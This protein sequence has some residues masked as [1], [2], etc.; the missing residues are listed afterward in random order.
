MCHNLILICFIHS[1]IIS[2][3]LLCYLMISCLYSHLIHHVYVHH[4]CLLAQFFDDVTCG[5]TS[6]TV[7]AAPLPLPRR[8]Q[9][10]NK[11]TPD[12]AVQTSG[13]VSSSLGK[14]VVWWIYW[15]LLVFIWGVLVDDCDRL[16]FWDCMWN[17]FLYVAN[18][19]H[20]CVVYF[21]GTVYA[22]CMMKNMVICLLLLIQ[23]STGKFYNMM[24][25][26]D[27]I[28]ICDILWVLCG[29]KYH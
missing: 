10:L 2:C 24:K 25:K 17:T 23:A 3:I 26:N 6:D 20:S 19:K 11:W 8:F 4:T 1:Y 28:L 18:L 22:P 29:V 7:T 13:Y 12:D 15:P 9:E 5:V 16:L 27:C 14:V 21:F